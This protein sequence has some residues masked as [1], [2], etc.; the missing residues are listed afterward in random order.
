[1][2]GFSIGTATGSGFGLIRRRPLSVFVW[3][4]LMIIPAAGSMAL[5]LPM[6]ETFMGEALRGDPEAIG[7]GSPMF[8]EMMRFQG[9]MSLVGV[10]RFVLGVVV[11]AAIIRAVVHPRDR[12]FFSLRLSMDEVRVFVVSLALIIGIIVGLVVLMLAATAVGAGLWQVAGAARGLAIAV[13]VIACLVG[14][15]LLGGRL[16]LLVPATVRFHTFAFTEGW[17]LG[18]GRSWS[19][20]GLLL[21]L[22]LIVFGI[23]IVVSGVVGAV[24]FIALGAGG[25]DPNAWVIGDNPFANLSALARANWPLL[26]VGVVASAALYGMLTAILTAPFASAVR[27]LSP[28][29][30]TADVF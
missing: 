27:Q 8:R 9:L 19:L 18:K 5:A 14:G 2:A 22:I 16:S 13:L 30:D 29:P 28:D 23:E 7:L 11:Y 1:M 4:L 17:A 12:R 26:A 10:V 3:G 6:M 20:V 15:L 25:F 21:V 24:M